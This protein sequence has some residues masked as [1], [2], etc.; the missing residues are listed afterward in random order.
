MKARLRGLNVAA[1]LTGGMFATSIAALLMTQLTMAQGA[2]TEAAQKAAENW[3]ALVDKGDYGASYDEAASFFKA[4]VTK[5]D[6][7]R[8]LKAVRGPLGN[9]ISRKLRS[10]EYKTSLP[11]APDG[12]YVVVQYDTSFDNKKSAVETIVPM[13]DKDGKW[14]V[15]GYFIR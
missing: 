9:V 14:R 13:L 5:D 10:A 2:K 15:S 11:G 12:Q 6:W 3:L 8:Q 1:S 4:A 7:V